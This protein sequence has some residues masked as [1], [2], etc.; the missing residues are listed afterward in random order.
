MFLYKIDS[1][2]IKIIT[3][4]NE[5]SPLTSPGIKRTSFRQLSKEFSLNI[6]HK[7]VMQNDSAF[8]INEIL[9]KYLQD[10]FK[11]LRDHSYLNTVYKH[12]VIKHKSTSC[13]VSSIQ[14]IFVYYIS[15]A[16]SDIYEFYKEKKLK[17]SVEFKHIL[18]NTFDNISK[19]KKNYRILENFI[20]K[21]EKCE[22]R[23]NFKR[24]RDNK[25]K[26][27][28]E[29]SLKYAVLICTSFI[30]KFIRKQK[31]S[32]FTLWLR[33]YMS[34]KNAQNPLR[35]IMYILET[36]LKHC[37]SNIRL[38][39][40]FD[41]KM[42]TLIRVAIIYQSFY[43]KFKS[44]GLFRG[45][46]SFRRYMGIE[47]Y[48][49]SIISIKT[50]KT[51]AESFEKKLNLNNS[52]LNDSPPVVSPVKLL[53]EKN[54]LKLNIGIPD[55]RHLTTT[56]LKED[57]LRKSMALTDRRHS[58]NSSIMNYKKKNEAQKTVDLRK[59]YDQKLKN[60]KIQMIREKNK[61]QDFSQARIRKLM[62]VAIEV[63]KKLSK[64]LKKQELLVLNSLIMA[65]PQKQK[66]IETWKVKIYALGFHKFSTN[67]KK[68]M[69][70]IFIILRYNALKRKNY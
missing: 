2:P 14:K 24:I 56:S 41:G 4:K 18:L 44:Y 10:A 3:N 27:I 5:G 46:K 62:K 66:Q 49:P 34:K 52:Y 55:G 11:L 38:S 25:I 70:G 22:K 6:E 13:L 47:C 43:E 33:Y 19:N 69:S 50:G 59:A 31:S 40:S 57:S 42:N 45:F 12:V 23:I 9:K 65:F 68:Y 53:V 7:S 61:S 48:T 30:D 36:R 37:F 54:K 63:D 16:F 28:N 17:R 21:I 67:I 15:I 8:K 26:K 58:T 20:S 51:F 32:I 60:R 39:S 29:I 1:E 64:I 35:H